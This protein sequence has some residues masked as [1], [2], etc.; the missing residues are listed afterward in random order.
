VLRIAQVVVV[1]HQHGGHD[2][3][4]FHSSSCYGSLANAVKSLRFFDD[5][6]PYA[7]LILIFEIRFCLTFASVVFVYIF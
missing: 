4:L 5:R 1:D 6:R 3:S 2:T 7:A